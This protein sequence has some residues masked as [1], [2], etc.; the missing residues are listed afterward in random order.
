LLRLP[1]PLP[2]IGGG[3]IVDNTLQQNAAHGIH[4]SSSV[5][6]P[7]A[8]YRQGTGFDTCQQHF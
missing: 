4:C 7:A 8:H 1:V 3:S 5:V 2:G 6:Q